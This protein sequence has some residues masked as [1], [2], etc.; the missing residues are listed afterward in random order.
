MSWVSKTFNSTLGKKLLMA[1][2]G[3]FLIL[4]LVGHVSGNT[5][6][7]KND[8]GQAFNEYAKFMTTNPFVKILS[9]VTYISVLVHVVYAI[10]LSRRN[11]SA[12]PVG[13]AVSKA[14]TNSSWN[15]RNMGILGTIILIFLVI[16]LQ[17]FWYQMHWGDV[18]MVEYNG[19]QY[20]DLFTIVQFAF[21]AEWL[22]ALYV[23]SMVMLG[24]HLAHG[25]ESA[26]QT[27]GLNHVKYS[28]A[29][30]KLGLL[31]SIIVPALFASMPLYIYFSSMN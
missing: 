7:F 28:P 6:L 21:Q 18:P 5:L 17:G 2:T 23:I 8:G 22:V 31:F 12:R 25:F 3:L 30:K 15:S 11:K 9:Y 26:F 29:I 24:F 16:H 27:L 4:F 1:L 10:F 20:K 14:A 19:E 13:Y